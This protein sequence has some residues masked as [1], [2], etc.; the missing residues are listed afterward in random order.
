MVVRNAEQKVVEMRAVPLPLVDAGNLS[1]G[2][3]A[4]RLTR[5]EDS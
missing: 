4:M 1:A 2:M 3:A 5:E